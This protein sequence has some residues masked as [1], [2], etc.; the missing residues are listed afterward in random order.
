MF[1]FFGTLIWFWWYRHSHTKY[2]AYL[3]SLF[4]FLSLSLSHY[5]LVSCEIV[6][7]R[8]LN[9]SQEKIVF[10]KQENWVNINIGQLRPVS[11]QLAL[12]TL[13]FLWSCL[14]ITFLILSN[15]LQ[16]SK[17]KWLNKQQQLLY[18][19]NQIQ[20]N[21]KFEFFLECLNYI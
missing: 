4:Y 1:L 15:H 11:S 13:L 18:Q 21:K 17:L 3:P 16:S 12:P 20:V 9:V 6:D 5:F 10:Q 14:F 2:F 7:K 19:I 8:K